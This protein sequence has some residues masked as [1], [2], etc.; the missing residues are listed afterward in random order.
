VLP[1]SIRQ[2]RQGQAAVAGDFSETKLKLSPGGLRCS[3]LSFGKVLGLQR[4]S[5]VVPLDFGWIPICCP[6]AEAACASMGLR[7][8][9]AGRWDGTVGWLGRPLGWDCGVAWLAVG[10]APGV[11]SLQRVAALARETSSVLREA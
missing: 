8:F 3:P 5:S 2:S 9:L 11:L 4:V 6:L 7:G 10:N 1:A